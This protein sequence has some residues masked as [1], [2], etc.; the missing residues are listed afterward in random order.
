MHVKVKEKTKMFDP[1][2]KEAELNCHQMAG[3]LDRHDLYNFL[4]D[5]NV[6]AFSIN[7]DQT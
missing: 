1:V 2:Q 7:M 6:A 4:C 5:R 3:F